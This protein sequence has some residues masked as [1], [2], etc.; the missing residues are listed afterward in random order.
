MNNLDDIS[1]TQEYAT[2]CGYTQQELEGYFG[3][4][5]NTLACSLNLCTEAINTKTKQWYN[6]YCFNENAQ[7]VYNPHSILSLLR[8]KAFGNF[9]FQ[10]ATPTV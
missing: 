5:L 4:A 9:W 3:D 10:S 8:H 2:L 6:G 7:R 1:L